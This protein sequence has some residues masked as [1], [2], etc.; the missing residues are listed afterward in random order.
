MVHINPACGSPCKDV[1]LLNYS[2]TINPS[3]SEMPP[4]VH[5]VIKFYDCAKVS[6]KI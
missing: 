4:A 5:L 3:V 1:G 2:T 6:R